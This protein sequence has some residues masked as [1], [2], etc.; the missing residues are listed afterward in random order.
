M[1]SFPTKPAC[2]KAY[3]IRGKVPSELDLD[4]AYRIGLSMARFLD[5]KKFIVGRD[6]RLSSQGLCEALAKGL[7][8]A[9]ADV[10]DIGVCG[11]EMVY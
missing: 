6:C 9:G 2:F 3:D 5:G 1:A 4:L 11:T 8:N 10:V 7:T